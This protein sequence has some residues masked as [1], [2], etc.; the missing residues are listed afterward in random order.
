MLRLDRK[1]K[2]ELKN[3]TLKVANSIW[4]S[5]F[6]THLY[7]F[8]GGLSRWLSTCRPFPLSSS[9]SPKCISPGQTYFNQFLFSTIPTQP[10]LPNLFRSS[11]KQF[12]LNSTLLR[13]RLV[14]SCASSQVSRRGLENVSLECKIAKRGL[15]FLLSQYAAL[16]LS[17]CSLPQSLRLTQVVFTT[18]T[19]S[20][21][22][23]L[24]AHCERNRRKVVAV[25]IVTTFH[26]IRVVYTFCLVR[27]FRPLKS[28]KAGLGFPLFQVYLCSLSGDNSGVLNFHPSRTLRE[29]LQ[30]GF[31]C[32]Y[33]CQ[34]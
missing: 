17:N 14:Q 26:M 5:P 32:S 18:A 15:F 4:K 31:V 24:R 33:H 13:A 16:C 7:T 27:F 11:V 12:V 8:S 28:C 29:L 21:N 19:S 25:V 3:K 20:F 2:A 10:T 22:T 6:R 1:R 30:T 9:W 34:R 23:S